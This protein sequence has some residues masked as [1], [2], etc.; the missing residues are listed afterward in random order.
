M[1][2]LAG[3]VALVTGATGLM[4]SVLARAYAQEGADVVLLARRVDKLE[5]LTRELRERGG[6]AACVV[7]DLADRQALD[8]AAAR[9]WDALGRIDIVLSNAA[10]SPEEQQSGTVLSTPDA[11][12]ER[13]HELIVWS[14]MRLLRALAPRMAAN[15]GGSII[16]VISTTGVQPTPGYDAYGL[17]KGTLLL[18]T[19][20]MAKEWGRDGIRVNAL[21]PGS[22]VTDPSTYETVHSKAQAHGILERISLGRLGTSA[23]V[24]GAAVYLASD[25]SRYFSGQVMNVDGGRL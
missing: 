22:I 21:N 20:Y 3:K 1:A 25:E 18:L 14:P 15:G 17:A 9:A 13:M 6:R 4:G 8:S 12:W 16:T 19:K 10:P 7:L 11:M 5:E 23:E 24:I 2:R